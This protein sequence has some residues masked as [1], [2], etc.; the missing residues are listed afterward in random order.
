MGWIDALKQ[1]VASRPKIE[2]DKLWAENAVKFYKMD[3]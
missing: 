3:V 2:Q 1:I